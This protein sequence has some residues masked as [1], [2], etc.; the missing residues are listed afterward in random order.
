MSS[1]LAAD[2]L[3]AHLA[4]SGLREG[5]RV[6]IWLPS[7]IEAAIAVLAEVFLLYQKGRDPPLLSGLRPRDLVEED[8]AK[9]WSHYLLLVAVE[10][11]FKNLKGDLA[12][13][14]I[15]HQLEARVEAHVFIALLAYC[16]HVT[17]ARR[18]HALARGLT[19]RAVLEKFAA[20]QMID[21]HLPTS[22]GRELLLSRYTEPEPELNLLLTKLKLE[23]PAQPPPKITA[24]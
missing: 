6:V 23:L 20:M 24:R 19:P 5:Q 17:L 14:P 22:D 16:L 3:A 15:F 11:V 8:P 2:Y 18:M 10:E 21:V 12:I 4:G 7:R 9:L 1:W 13:R